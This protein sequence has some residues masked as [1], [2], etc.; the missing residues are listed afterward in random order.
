MHNRLIKFKA[1]CSQ[2]FRPKQSQ[3]TGPPDYK[4]RTIITSILM[5][6]ISAI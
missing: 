5:D 4:D 6:K 3:T 1:D 2:A